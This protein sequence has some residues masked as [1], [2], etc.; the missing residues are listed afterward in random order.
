VNHPGICSRRDLEEARL[1]QGKLRQLFDS[2][3]PGAADAENLKEMLRLCDRALLA[4]NDEYCQDQICE[5][6]RH[7]LKLFSPSGVM[8][9]RRL[10]LES[11]E[12]IGDRLVSLQVMSRSADAVTRGEAI[13]EKR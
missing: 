13:L 7:A 6:E 2:A 12:A 3:H 11:L 9:Q 4:V 1:L 8:F 10:I 5:V